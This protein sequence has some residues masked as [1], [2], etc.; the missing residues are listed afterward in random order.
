MLVGTDHPTRE[1]MIGTEGIGKCNSNGLLL[2]KKCAEHELL[3]TNTVFRLPTRNKTSW[4]H[5]RSKHWHLIYYVI[6]RRKDRKDVRVTNKRQTY[7]LWKQRTHHRSENGSLKTVCGAD[8][9]A[10]H[11]LVTKLNLRI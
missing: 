8:C 5:P 4:M 3:I 10:D 7:C 1:G 6:V 9:W 2:L 11:R